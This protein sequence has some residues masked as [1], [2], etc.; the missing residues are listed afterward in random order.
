MTFR[1]GCGEHFLGLSLSYV[2]HLPIELVRLVENIQVVC[3]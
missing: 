2:F 1:K 3:M